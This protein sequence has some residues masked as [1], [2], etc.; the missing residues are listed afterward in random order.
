MRAPEFW[1]APPGLAAGLLTPLGTVWDTAARL[2]RALT[3]PYRA[4]VPVVCVGNLVA[5]GS[6]KTPVVL[7]LA[8]LA[9]R[10]M[11]AHVVTRGYGGR[12][13]GPVRV[14]PTR[15]DAIAVGDEALLIAA[16]TPCW[17]A[18]DR[19]AGIRAAATAGAE[20]VLL[21]DG[22]QNPSIA[23]NLSLVVVD[24]EYGFGNSR[25]MPAGPLREPIGAGL[26]RA[27]AIVLI[28]KDDAPDSVDRAGRP[29]LRATLVPRHADRVAGARVVAFAGI[30]R[31]AKFFASL[32]ASGAIVAA[33]QSFPDHHP[34]TEIQIARLRQQASDSDAILVTTAKDWV[35]LPSPLR[36]DIAVF[37]VDLRWHDECEVAQLLAAVLRHPAHDRTNG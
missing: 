33:T 34:F 27:D 37:K 4:P 2:R 14:D 12:L 1:H 32:T 24:A 28:G 6:G 8:R 9:A 16:V 18:R 26:A 25:V 20:L 35:R 5:G 13:A 11:A 29:V 30:G 22:F 19:A 15:H 21:D 36:W 10:H 31:P 3:R 17:I 23:K 7:S